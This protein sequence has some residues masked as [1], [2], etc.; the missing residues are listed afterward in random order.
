MV[1]KYATEGY[2]KD[3]KIKIVDIHLEASVCRSQCKREMSH[4]KVVTIA[5]D[6]L[7]DQHSSC[8]HIIR[9]Y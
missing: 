1:L 7:L 8:T 9:L 3:F 5:D 6:N 4:I 2:I